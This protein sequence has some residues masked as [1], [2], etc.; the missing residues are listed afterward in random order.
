MNP[1]ILLGSLGNFLQGK[2]G[3]FIEIYMLGG[4][5]IWTIRKYVIHNCAVQAWDIQKVKFFRYLN[6]VMKLFISEKFSY[7]HIY[8]IIH[9]II[10]LTHTVHIF[11]IK[12]M[13]RAQNVIITMLFTFS[14]ANCQIANTVTPSVEAL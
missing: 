1:N 4:E 10:S 7:H 8:I 12:M 2:V 6:L 3:Y 13:H 14:W 9:A 5:K 11:R